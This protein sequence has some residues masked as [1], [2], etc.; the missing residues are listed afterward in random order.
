[1]QAIQHDLTLNAGASFQYALQWF[2]SQAVHTP[3]TGVAQGW[4]TIVTAPGHG[5]NIGQRYPVWISNVRV[6]NN[7]N[8]PKPRGCS[9]L[10]ADVMDT[11]TLAVDTNTGQQTGSYSGTGIMTTFPVTDL[12]GYTADLQ[13]RAAP[14]SPTVLI[15]LS[16]TNGGITLDPTTGTV[17]LNVSAAQTAAL[18]WSQGVYDLLLTSSTGF[19][20]RLAQGNVIVTQDVTRS[21]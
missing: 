13:V 17:T 21:D 1:M 14:G 12:T 19:V 7:L 2:G 20:T 18:A 16:T 11:N 10:F 5:L 6:P 15:E 9:P 4:P 3:I 8:T